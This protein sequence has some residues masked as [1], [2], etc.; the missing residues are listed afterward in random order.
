MSFVKEVISALSLPRV[1]FKRGS[2]VLE[3]RAIIE[4]ETAKRQE[5]NK[6]P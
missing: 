3:I 2:T 4:A 6:A 1:S 5:A